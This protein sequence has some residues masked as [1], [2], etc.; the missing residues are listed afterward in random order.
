M[1]PFSRPVP[2]DTKQNV[3]DNSGIKCEHRSSISSMLHSR[4][5]FIICSVAHTINFCKAC[6]SGFQQASDSIHGTKN[7]SKISSKLPKGDY[8]SWWQSI[9]SLG[10][11]STS[12]I[13]L[14]RH[15]PFL[16]GQVVY[17]RSCLTGCPAVRYFLSTMQQKLTLPA[18]VTCNLRP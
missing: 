9:S 5:K 10:P 1:Q 2:S 6:F 4:W 12:D 7:P 15:W 14:G 16:M 3:G 11:Q 17:L 8:N 18:E 13:W